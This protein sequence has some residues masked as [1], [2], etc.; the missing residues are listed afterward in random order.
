M[1]SISNLDN[2]I[3]VI[4]AHRLSTVKNCDKIFVLN[5][6]KIKDRTFDEL[7]QKVNLNYFQKMYKIIKLII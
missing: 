3:T 6:G 2:G 7:I 5:K 1:N 4:M